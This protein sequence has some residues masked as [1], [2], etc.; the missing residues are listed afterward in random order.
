MFHDDYQ[1]LLVGRILYGTAT[2]LLHTAFDA[3]MSAQHAEH[4]FP[5]D[6][7]MQTYQEVSRWTAVVSIGAGVLAEAAAAVAGLAAPFVASFLLA[8]GGVALIHAT[9]DKQQVGGSAL[10]G[11]GGM[12]GGG[13][14]VSCIDGSAIGAIAGG[15][16]DSIRT[17]AQLVSS[18]SSSSSSSSADAALLPQSSSSSPSPAA[19]GRGALHLVVVQACF[20]TAM[21][22]ALFM[23][24]PVLNASAA[25]HFGIG[26]PPPYGIIFSLLMTSVM[27]G[28]H[29][30]QIAAGIAAD[31]M[32]AQQQVGG[33]VSE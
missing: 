30:F 3:W 21:Y 14:S 16:S 33:W 28:S 9:W 20:E 27:L 15:V 13:G 8:I 22:I 1:T 5:R 4:A 11:M 10:G 7:Q 24:T 23:W 32:Q 6:W 19:A 29:A 25:E 12:G 17:T 31:L 2:A 26:I 18:V